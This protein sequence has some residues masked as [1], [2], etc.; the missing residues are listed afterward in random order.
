MLV[1]VVAVALGS[2][3]PFLLV[4]SGSVVSSLVS[5]NLRFFARLVLVVS[6]A[7][8]IEV[9]MFAVYLRQSRIHW[10]SIPN[11]G[12]SSWKSGGY[13]SIAKPRKRSHRSHVLNVS[14]VS[15]IPEVRMYD[16]PFLIS[17]RHSQHV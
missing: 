4:A 7:F 8:V 1:V 9:S 13:F 14:G 17:L 10:C 6:F 11:A 2:I 12:P 16:W 3:A 15:Q 5:M